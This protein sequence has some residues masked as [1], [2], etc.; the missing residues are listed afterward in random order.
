MQNNICP[1]ID[2][3]VP[4]CTNTHRHM[5]ITHIITK[6]SEHICRYIGT[7]SC[8][9]THTAQMFLFQGCLAPFSNLIFLPLGTGA[10]SVACSNRRQRGLEGAQM[11]GHMDLFLVRVSMG[12]AWAVCLSP[13]ED[14]SRTKLSSERDGKMQ[15]RALSFKP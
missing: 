1:H 7:D 8:N 3:C 2:T 10:C 13:C 14:C 15:A 5:Y 9:T 4:S 6:T 12:T 11:A